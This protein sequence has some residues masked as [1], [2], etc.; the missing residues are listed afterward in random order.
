[1]RRFGSD[2]GTDDGGCGGGGDVVLETGL[3]DCDCEEVI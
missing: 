1:M 2:V 3:I